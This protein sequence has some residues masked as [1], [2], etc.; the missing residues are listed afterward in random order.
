MAE[1]EAAVAALNETIIATVDTI[2]A[3][4]DINAGFTLQSGYMVFF[5]QASCDPYKALAPQA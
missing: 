5:M 3:I 2:P 1:L 4:S